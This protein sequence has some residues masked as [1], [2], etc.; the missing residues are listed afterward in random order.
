MKNLFSI[1][2][3]W[4]MINGT[5]VNTD[6]I[7]YIKY[8]PDSFSLIIFNGHSQELQINNLKPVEVWNVLVK[9]KF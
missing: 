7:S 5:I 2:L 1:V 8:Y 9:N 3:F 6:N 4:T